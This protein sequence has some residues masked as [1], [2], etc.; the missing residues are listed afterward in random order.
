MAFKFISILKANAEITRLE[1]ELDAAN[2]RLTEMAD[3]EPEALAAVQ[4]ELKNANDKL[5]QTGSDLTTAKTSF[6]S[7]AK[8]NAEL[9]AKVAELEAKAVEVDKAAS[10]KAL[11]IA[12]AQGIP[13]VEAK[14]AVDPTTQAQP[15]AKLHGLEL[16]ASVFEAQ[17]KK[18]LGKK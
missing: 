1:T 15:A 2:T 4:A 6:E 12:A 18:L 7:L 10:A 13:P 16:T 17:A 14:P 11:E 5:A 9:T 8:T 3:N